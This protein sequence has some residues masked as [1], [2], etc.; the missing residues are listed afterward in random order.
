MHLHII[1][2]LGLLHLELLIKNYY[3]KQLVLN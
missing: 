2:I 1:V 3:M